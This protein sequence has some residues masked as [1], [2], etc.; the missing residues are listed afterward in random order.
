MQRNQHDKTTPPPF[1]HPANT[2]E[3]GRQDEQ[4]SRVLIRKKPAFFKFVLKLKFV[5]IHIY[6]I[7]ENTYISYI[8][9]I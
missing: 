1:P 6:H 5:R 2:T 9:C 8:Y 7:C 4:N 3:Q